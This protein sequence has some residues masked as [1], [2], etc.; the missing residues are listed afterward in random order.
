RPQLGELARQARVV[1]VD[2]F[3]AGA[4]ACAAADLV[5]KARPLARRV[6]A[7]RLQAKPVRV[8]DRP[9]RAVRRALRAKQAVEEGQRVGIDL[10]R[11]GQAQALEVED[12]A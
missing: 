7:Q 9:Q 2:I 8:G 6:E 10:V 12:E 4:H 5:A 11:L 1:L 3:L